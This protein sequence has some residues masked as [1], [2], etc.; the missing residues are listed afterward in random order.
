MTEKTTIAWQLKMLFQMPVSPLRTGREIR[1]RTKFQDALLPLVLLSGFLFI[2]RWG[3][4]ND[5]GFP[6][7][8][9]VPS[10]ILATILSK[11]LVALLLHV[12][13]IM[14]RCSAGFRK[15]FVLICYACVFPI[16][17][18]T[19]TKATNT[20]I[21]FVVPQALVWIYILP[22]AIAGLCN[23]S[24]FRGLGF[25]Y[26]T[27]LLSAVNNMVEWYQ[28]YRKEDVVPFQAVHWEGFFSHDVNV[29]LIVLLIV[30]ALSVNAFRNRA[31]K[32]LAGVFSALFLVTSL[33][34][35]IMDFYISRY[36]QDPVGLTVGY[37]VSDNR[38][39]MWNGTDVAEYDIDSG[40]LIAT[41]IFKIKDSWYMT[42]GTDG[43]LYFVSTGGKNISLYEY[44]KKN[45][46]VF[47][48]DSETHNCESIN[49]LS[50]TNYIFD[51]DGVFHVGCYDGRI[52]KYS[53]DGKMLSEF[54]I[55][56]KVKA[57]SEKVDEV[58]PPPHILFGFTIDDKGNYY[59]NMRGGAVMKLSPEGEELSTFKFN[60]KRETAFGIFYSREGNLYTLST[61]VDREN[62]SMKQRLRK[63]DTDGNLQ[64]EVIINEGKYKD[65]RMF[66]AMRLGKGDKLVLKKDIDSATVH[67]SYLVMNSNGEMQYPIPN[68][69]RIQRIVMAS[70]RFN[71]RFCKLIIGKKSF[72]K[73]TF[74]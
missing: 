67:S 41:K 53:M 39:Y 10:I 65:A 50:G 47:S 40:K 5:S 36:L 18:S 15:S 71:D 20:D 2:N 17:I 61:E 59:A 29:V 3:A 74:M 23:V 34:R 72:Y 27:T 22:L 4:M 26:F 46:P 48:I 30:S 21:L 16:L 64:N 32:V 25:Y 49:R 69:K 55:D 8:I 73:S 1:E 68:N 33:G 66:R 9:S 11:F 19:V 57:S 63:F 7:H 12:I 51:K 6:W 44:G 52:Q 28:I 38:I 24:F 45:K 31:L 37:Y 56:F 54:A 13:A 62:D 35:G 60:E 43:T 58:E 14:F 42:T 70:Y